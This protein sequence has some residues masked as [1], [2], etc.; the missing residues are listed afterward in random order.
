MEEIL[1]KWKTTSQGSL[2]KL[3][4]KVI[5]AAWVPYTN[6]ATHIEKRYFMFQLVSNAP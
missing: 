5:H 2:D 3:P 1:S 6:I 4:K